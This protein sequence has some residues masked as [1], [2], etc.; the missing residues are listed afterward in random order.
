MEQCYE[1]ALRL[2]QKAKIGLIGSVDDA[3]FPNIKAVL[4]ADKKPGMAEVV[5]K[6][7]T[8]S[9]HAR[10][11]KEN[12]KGCLYL[13]S[14][15]GFKGLMLRGTYAVVEDAELKKQYWKKGDEKYYQK[16]EQD[17]CL[18]VFTPQSGRY[19][20]RYQTGEF[21]IQA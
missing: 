1:D 5:I 21:E 9:R 16:G 15:L 8:S 13:Y 11:F 19:Y 12:P 7:N 17:Y 14:L 10:Q 6:T 18:L 20:H 2:Y 4:M 3:G